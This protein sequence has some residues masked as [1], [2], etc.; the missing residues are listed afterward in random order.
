READTMPYLRIWVVISLASETAR[1][2]TMPLRLLSFRLAATGKRPRITASL[3]AGGTP[4]NS[5][6]MVCASAGRVDLM[7][8]S[9]MWVQPPPVTAPLA[10]MMM[11][12]ALLVAIKLSIRATGLSATAAGAAVTRAGAAI[13]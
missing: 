6:T 10:W 13:A 3:E 7:G 4:T 8:L 2:A 12:P 11:R 9:V 5:T 1:T